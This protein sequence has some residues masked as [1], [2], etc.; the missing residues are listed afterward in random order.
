MARLSGLQRDVLKLCRQ[1]FRTVRTK[2]PEYQ[3]HW[4]AYIKQEFAK[5][6]LVSKKQFSVIEHLLRVGHRRLEMYLS[7]A[8]KNVH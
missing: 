1:S 5:N 2:P 8:I 7:P 6:R 3:A 4:R